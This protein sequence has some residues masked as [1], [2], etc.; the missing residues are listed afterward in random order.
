MRF[1]MFTEDVVEIFALHIIFFNLN[2]FFLSVCMQHTDKMYQES[3]CFFLGGGIFW[4][5]VL[6]D[7]WSFRRLRPLDPTT[8]LPWTH[9]PTGGGGLQQPP[10]QAAAP[11]N[12]IRSLH[13][14]PSAGYHFIYALTT[15]SAHHSKFL[16]KR[17]ESRVKYV[18]RVYDEFNNDGKLHR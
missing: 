4:Y 2:E 13:I 16:K 15:N 3:G 10:R 1:E 5:C 11:G 12:D 14:V 9:G 6:Q 7:R 18:T 8:A 17:P